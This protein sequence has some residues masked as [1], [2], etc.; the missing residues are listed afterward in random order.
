[1]KWQ[2]ETSIGNS[3]GILLTHYFKSNPSMVGSPELHGTP[4][5]Y[6]GAKHRRRFYW[7]KNTLNKISWSC[8]EYK[9]GSFLL[10][11]G[12]GSPFHNPPQ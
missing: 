4:E 7:I 10:S 9:D 2:K 6:H 12:Q 5:V 11:E 8:V 3:D 1:M